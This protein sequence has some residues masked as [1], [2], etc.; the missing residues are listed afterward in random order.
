M[1]KMLL[2]S[3]LGSMLAGAHASASVGDVRVKMMDEIASQVKERLQL[4]QE[5]AKEPANWENRNG[6]RFFRFGD[7]LYLM[8]S[9]NKPLFM[10]LVLGSSYDENIAYADRSAEA[11]F[12][13]IQS[14]WRLVNEQ[15]GVYIY[16]DQFG[17]SYMNWDLH[18]PPCAVRY[19]AGSGISVNQ[20]NCLPYDQK[21]TD[22]IGFIDDEPITNHLVG[23]YAA[24]IQFIQNQSSE[25]HGNSDKF[26]QKL[27]T[28]REALL[29][30]TPEKGTPDEKSV[31]LS[32]FKDGELV[33]KRVLDNPY[34]IMTADRTVKDDRPDIV[35]SKRSYSTVLPWNYIEKGLS[36]QLD[37]YD[38]RRGELLADSIEFSAP[39][40][41]EMPMIRIGMLTEPPA[42]KQ[43]ETQ[44]ANYGAELFQRY[45]FATMTISPYLPVQ[46]DKIVTAFGEVETEYSEF[47]KPGV[48]SGDL[49]ENITKSLI[50]TGINNANYGVTSTAGTSQWQ[51]AHFPSVVIGHSIGRYL[52]DDN[53][54]VDVTHGLS[55]GNGMALLVDAVGNEVTHEIGHAFSLG[56]WPGGPDYYYHSTWSGWGY[57]AYRGRMSDNLI[58]SN[59]GYDDRDFKGL[60]GYQKDPMGGGNFDSSA[61]AYPIF[62]NYTSKIMQDYL[63]KYDLLDMQSETGYVRWDSQQESM[64]DVVETDKLKPR[65]L[66]A[67]VMTMVGYYD[68]S[69]QN[70]SYIYPPMYGASGK[71][72]DLPEPSVGQC[73]TDVTYSNGSVDRIGLAGTRIDSRMSNKFHINIERAAQP[74]EMTIYCPERSLSDI[75][76][77]VILAEVQQERFFDWGENNRTGQPGDIFHYQRNGRLELFELKQNHYWYFPE[78]GLS[79]S[80]WQFIGYF[81]ELVEQYRVEQKPSFEDLGQIELAT[82][83]FKFTD[84]YPQA[85]VTFGKDFAGYARA[86]ESVLTFDAHSQL[87]TQRFAHLAEFEKA[88]LAVPQYQL[89]GQS[90][91]I[92]NQ[93]EPKS[94][95]IGTIHALNNPVTGTRD[96]FMRKRAVA[97]DMPT[98]QT[99]NEDWK[100]L[101]QAEDYVNFALNPMSLSRTMADHD[102]R[103]AA[104]YDVDAPLTVEMASQ[105][106]KPYQLFVTKLAD[107]Q[108]GYFLQKTLG[109][110]SPMPT[111]AQSDSNW[112]FIASTNTL[113][114]QLT[115]WQDRAQFEQDAL[116]WNQ[117]ETMGEWGD[118]QQRGQI[119]HYYLYDFKNDGKRHYY[120]LKTERYSYFPW[121]STTNPAESSNHNWQYLTHF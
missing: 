47:A 16:H 71:V 50:Q 72:Y 1:K 83:Q 33:E 10:P 26:Q 23:S 62:T 108:K 110:S 56:H 70:M 7:Y 82:H 44:M 32:I 18:R 90:V 111:D 68:P 48:Y 78:T 76:R 21:K 109:H 28:H 9:E 49:R 59:R 24:R 99:S 3:L 88:I 36:L 14:P 113:N 77:E 103:M 39:I 94:Q 13:F 98:N 95:F 27:V 53:E 105:T 8:S 54:V 107:G 65:L 30:V 31:V 87:A 79:N 55:G 120:R 5:M 92:F 40:H 4:I 114:A 101:G 91:Q 121:P 102:Q 57:D 20:K 58:W 69:Q 84:L 45:P 73:W 67:N 93:N 86:I 22:A 63:V 11:M 85:A 89:F 43:L 100:Y 112:R 97:S 117:Q 38:M 34:Q 104:Y 25:A 116:A 75:V 46:F 19:I 118:N 66:D 29:I 37:T 51:P 119:G 96:Y 15:D 12:D 41:M 42:A 115:Q 2:A 64:V 17:T 6:Q 60:V 80:E 52:N 35:F 106:M 81:D 74:K 61:S